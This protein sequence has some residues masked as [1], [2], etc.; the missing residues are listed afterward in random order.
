LSRLFHAGRDR[1]DNVAVEGMGADMNEETH[2]A[3]LWEEMMAGK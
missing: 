2:T 3:G 1:R